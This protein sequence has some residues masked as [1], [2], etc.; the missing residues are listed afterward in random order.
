MQVRPKIQSGAWSKHVDPLGPNQ[1]ETSVSDLRDFRDFWALNE[2]SGSGLH[3]P[4]VRSCL[5]GVGWQDSGGSGAVGV[6]PSSIPKVN[7]GFRSNRHCL[8]GQWVDGSR[9]FRGPK[10]PTFEGLR[11]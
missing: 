6:N 8:E 4:N 1:R 2:E 3:D 9:D 5:Q 10:G 7:R 11:K